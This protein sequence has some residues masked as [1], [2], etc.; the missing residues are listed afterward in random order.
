MNK[1]KCKYTSI[2]K[3]GEAWKEQNENPNAGNFF[4]A[5]WESI[6]IPFIASGELLTSVYDCI[7]IFVKFVGLMP[8]GS[9]VQG[10]GIGGSDGG[11]GGGGGSRPA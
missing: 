3:T 8:D 10:G 1:F 11:G 9:N 5:L 6:K 2:A 4:K 7:I